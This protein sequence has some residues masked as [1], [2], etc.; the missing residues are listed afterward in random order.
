MD[1]LNCYIIVV[2]THALNYYN[3][4]STDELFE[5]Y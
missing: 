5:L 2:L 4:S 1:A 3:Y